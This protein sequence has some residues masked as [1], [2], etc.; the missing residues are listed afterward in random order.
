[1][2]VQLELAHLHQM[3]TMDNI[4]LLLEDTLHMVGREAHPWGLAIL[5]GNKVT[6]LNILGVTDHLAHHLTVRCI[7]NVAARP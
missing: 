2:V 3:D 7:H 6:P 4:L 5:C 1:M